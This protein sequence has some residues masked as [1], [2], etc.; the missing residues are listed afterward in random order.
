MS[1]SRWAGP[2]QVGQ[3]VLTQSAHVGQRR[4]A[5]A[6]RLVGLDVGQQHGQLVVRHGNLAAVRAVDD[7][8]GRAPVALAGDQPVAHLVVHLALADALLLHVGSDAGDA[9]LGRSGR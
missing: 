3:V 1:V 4:A 6:G 2:P 9:F 8:D 7:R 5:V